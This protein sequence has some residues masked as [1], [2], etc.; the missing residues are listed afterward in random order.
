MWRGGGRSAAGGKLISEMFYSAS[1]WPKAKH[2]K[3]TGLK[4]TWR[5]FWPLLT[6]S[7]IRGGVRR[8]FLPVGDR[9]MVSGPNGARCENVVS[10]KKL[11]KKN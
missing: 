5:H 11:A 8:L 10:K 4:M 9:I 2:A 6:H 1:G 3:S 7:D